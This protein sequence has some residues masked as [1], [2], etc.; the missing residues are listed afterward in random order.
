MNNEQ[1]KATKASITTL[2]S[3]TGWKSSPKKIFQQQR[4]IKTTTNR[5]AERISLSKAKAA[6]ST[7][8]RGEAATKKTN[9]QTNNN[10]P[11]ANETD[12]ES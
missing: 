4:L 9:K 2:N 1:L 10:Y 8:H 11:V 5:G 6:P 3:P 12:E 7:G